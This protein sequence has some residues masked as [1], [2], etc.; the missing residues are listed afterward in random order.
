MPPQ[1]LHE[2]L[3]L[4]GSSKLAFELP[5]THVKIQIAKIDSSKT[6]RFWT[7]SGGTTTT[8]IDIKGAKRILSISNEMKSIH[9]I[10]LE[11]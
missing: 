8:F 11:G 1:R 5:K 2:L 4:L 10:H 3:P 7:T 6:K 9:L